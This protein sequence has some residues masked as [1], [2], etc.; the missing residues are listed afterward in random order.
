LSGNY[1]QYI[2]TI[3][4]SYNTNTNNY[5]DRDKDIDEHDRVY[6]GIAGREFR[7]RRAGDSDANPYH[8]KNE[9]VT[10]TFGAGSNIEGPTKNDP[11]N[12]FIDI[13]DIPNFPA[14]VRSEPNTGEWEIVA[15]KVE[16][17]PPTS[18]LTIKYPRIILDDD[19]GERVDLI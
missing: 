1:S 8:L 15:A 3:F 18:I 11:R 5:Y 10:L 13:A 12:P 9:T 4:D 2:F 16:T 6:L 14:Y 19:S 17:F 7:C